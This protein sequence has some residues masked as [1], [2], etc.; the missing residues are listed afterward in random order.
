MKEV[1]LV[2]RP[3]NVLAEVMSALHKR[4]VKVHLTLGDTF[5]GCKTVIMTFTD[6]L[7]DAEA[8]AEALQEYPPM[9]S[10]AEK[11]GV[12]RAIVVG[13]PQSAAF[14]ESYLRRH[15]Q[16]NGRFISTEGDFA[17]KVASEVLRPL[18]RGFVRGCAVLWF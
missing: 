7:T 15:P 17:G 10:E 3:N 8:N 18:G 11:A 12:E 14:F 2:G 13:S 9:L 4:D 1:A 5:A 6:D 16:L